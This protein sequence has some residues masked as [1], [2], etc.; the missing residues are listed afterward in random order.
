MAHVALS[1]F[2]QFAGV[3]LHNKQSTSI[4]IYGANPCYNSGNRWL[5]NIQ[6][7][8]PPFTGTSKHE[9]WRFNCI[10]VCMCYTVCWSKN[11]PIG[12]SFKKNILTVTL[13]KVINYVDKNDQ[14]LVLTN[15]LIWCTHF[16]ARTPTLKV[17]S[18]I[19]ISISRPNVR[20]IFAVLLWVKMNPLCKCK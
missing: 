18:V 8:T 16:S 20:K 11:R 19:W 2:V 13:Y 3:I 9:E 4:K 10:F 14:N 1:I 15:R 7:S 5:R 6:A 12:S 17:M